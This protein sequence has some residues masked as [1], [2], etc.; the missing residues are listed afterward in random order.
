MGFF[1]FCRSIKIAPGIRWNFGKKSTSLSIG[2]RGANYTVGTSGSRTTVGIPGTGLSYTAYLAKI[3][4]AILGDRIPAPSLPLA[5]LKPLRARPT[6]CRYFFFPLVGVGL[7]SMKSLTALTTT[8]LRVTSALSAMAWSTSF[9][10][11][12]MRTVMIPSRL[13]G[14]GGRVE[15]I[16]EIA[17]SL[18]GVGRSMG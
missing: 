12:G 5:T 10:S 4:A 16:Q 6:D 2:G 14:M 17:K 3:S 9:S 15:V 8:S 18:F 13:L 1:R 11:V 7:A